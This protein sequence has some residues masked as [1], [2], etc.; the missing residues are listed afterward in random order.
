MKDKDCMTAVYTYDELAAAYN[1]F[2][3]PA[4]AVYI[5]DGEE[6]IIKAQEIAIDNVQ[7]T[8]SAEEPAG[9]SL[10]IVNAFDLASHSVKQGVKDS[11]KVGTVIKVA[12]GYG[13]NLTTVFKGYVTE[14][15]TSYQD[16]PVVSVTAVDVRKLL[17]KNK[18]E[19]YKHNE[20]T[21]SG[22]FEKILDNYS[23]LYDALH[24]DAVEAKEE[25]RQNGT[26]Y[27]FIR[28]ELCCRANREFFVVG[29][30]VYFKE[31]GEEEA[32]FL[33]LQWG[34]SLISFQKGKSYCN[35][36]V[37]VYSSQEDKTGNMV[38]SEIKTEEDTP[39][40][41]AETQIEEW[42]P[43]ERMDLD[44]LQNWLER[45]VSE[46]KKKSETANGRLVG[47]PEIVPGRYIEIEGVDTAD[48][49]TY[50][51]RDVSHSFGSDGFTTSFTVGEP[52]DRWIED[53]EKKKSRVSVRSKGVMRAVVKENWNEEQP[54]KVLVQ[55]LTGEE[56][57]NITKWLPVLN[58][59]C[60]NGYGFYFHPEVDTEVVVASLAGDENSLFV[61]G[62]LW[63][64]ADVLP[65]STAGENNTIKRIRTKGNHEIVFDDEEEAAK[66]QI[67]TS[68]RL[69]LEMDDGAQCISLF[70]EKEE[71]GFKIDVAE[72]SFHIFAEKKVILT[73][74]GKDV[75]VLEGSKKVAIEAEQ[76]EEKGKQNFRIQ[77][78]K[79]EIKGDMTELKASSSMKLDN[80]G[81]TEI[82]GSVVKIN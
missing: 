50:Y 78:Q 75:V 15:R 14:Y 67:N 73:A 58:P 76:I 77:T 52:A 1:N 36:Q 16:M 62:N 49:G 10:E 18:R 51:V 12:L 35:E 8:L 4:M 54:G 56:G 7:V 30:N 42:E 17:M 2:L 37:K 25:L 53:E 31:P 40:L 70:D 55:F 24:V 41:T 74:G 64:Q 60:G 81:M 20:D 80:S 43:G 44:T 28:K 21:Y 59:Y 46:K 79:L 19:E 22:I 11:F 47:L 9:L 68:N 69:H 3:V 82:K 63:N 72:G 26:D 13:S 32:A 23:S 61:M 38:S 5:G 48:E 39:S 66:I 65:D 57:K 71:N 33:K 27:D 29:G 6:D 45:K 34:T